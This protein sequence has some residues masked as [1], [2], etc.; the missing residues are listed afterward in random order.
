LDLQTLPVGLC[1]ACRKDS[2]AGGALLSGFGSLARGADS[3]G[4]DL[5]KSFAEGNDVDR[6]G[7]RTVYNRE[8]QFIPLL[9]VVGTAIFV[10]VC[11][12]D[13]TEPCEV[14]FDN[15]RQLVSFRRKY[16]FGDAN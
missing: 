3:L 13:G 8:S 4:D 9:L 1:R 7:F 12:T 10:T 6:R 2:R 5:G 14:A 15:I 16:F 11:L